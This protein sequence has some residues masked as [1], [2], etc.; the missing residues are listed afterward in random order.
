MP[1]NPADSLEM[2]RALRGLV[3]LQAHRDRLRA[4]EFGVSTAGADALDALARLGPISLNRLAAELIVDKST[5]C[6]VVALLEARGWVLRAGDPADGR[7]LRLHLTDP[8]RALQVEL[9]A[10]AAWETQAVW[11]A[12]DEQQRPVL[13]AALAA[14]T[15]VAARQAGVHA[16]DDA[17]PL[18][19]ARSA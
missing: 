6:R 13:R 14:W 17:I 4:A 1:T 5:A 10:D 12:L 19:A 15:A 8:G 7:A 3:R 11:R 18:S 9:Q 16:P 2:H